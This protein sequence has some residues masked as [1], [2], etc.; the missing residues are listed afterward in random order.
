MM[1]LRG[2]FRRGGRVDEYEVDH[3]GVVAAR[4]LERDVTLVELGLPGQLKFLYGSRESVDELLADQESDFGHVQLGRI[5]FPSPVDC[6]DRGNCLRLGQVVWSDD[7]SEVGSI[8]GVS[9]PKQLQLDGIEGDIRVGVLVKPLKR[10]YVLAIEGG[11]DPDD[12][13]SVRAGT[14]GKQL[15][16]VAVIARCQLILNNNDARERPRPECR[17]SN[18]PRDA[19]S[20]GVLR[21]GR[22]SRRGARNFRPAKA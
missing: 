2:A 10:C 20:S 22:A 3:D 5:P 12:D 11:S 9:D 19:Q 7:G 4:A 16:E 15:T 21:Q 8:W 17:A 13:A 14:V 18:G 1:G 6:I